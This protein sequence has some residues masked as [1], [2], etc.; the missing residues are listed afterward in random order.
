MRKYLA[1]PSL[2]DV[3]KFKKEKAGVKIYTV[4]EG[5]IPD[6]G[7]G[8]TKTG[9]PVARIGEAVIKAPLDQVKRAGGWNERRALQKRSY[10]YIPL[11]SSLL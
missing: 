3:G 10:L 5:S 6:P 8:G 11:P 7:E 9:L 4:K 2:D 1:A